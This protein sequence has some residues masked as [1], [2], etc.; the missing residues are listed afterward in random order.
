MSQIVTTPTPE[1]VLQD[2]FGLQAFRQGQAEIIGSVLAGQDTLAV[3][4]TG[5]GKSICYQIPGLIL[6][7]LTLVVSPLIALMEDQAQA[8]DALG[9]AAGCIH[10][11]MDR[12]RKAEVFAAMRESDDFVLYISPERACTEGFRRWFAARRVGLLAVDE[13]HCVSQWGHDFRPDYARIGELRALQPEV[14]MLALTATATPEVLEDI[15]TQLG[16]RD[17][18]R[19]VFGFYRPNLYYQVEPCDDEAV[20]DAWLR[21]AIEQVPE[22]RVLVYCGTR[23]QTERLGAELSRLFPQVGYYHAGLDAETRESIQRAYGAGEIRVLCATNAFGMGIDHPDVRL[24]VH[25][26]L[27]GNLESLYQ[28]MGRAGRDRNESTCLLLWSRRDIVLQRW[29]IDQSDGVAPPIRRRRKRALDLLVQYAEGGECRHGGILTYF[30]DSRRIE[31][32]GHCDACDPDSPRRIAVVP[33]VTSAM[34]GARN[35]RSRR[36]APA[37]AAPAGRA[38]DGVDLARFEALRAWRRETAMARGLPAFMVL[39]DKVL[40]ALA[41][42]DPS[43]FDELGSIHGMGPKRVDEFGADILRVLGGIEPPGEA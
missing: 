24:V 16:L 34:T 14:P 43:T 1:Q 9:I 27:P 7:G 42:H 22:G 25:A 41:V 31:S 15:S 21:A 4:P 20:R 19:H 30:R 29:F 18:D 38:L 39:S 3:M 17:P 12:R 40:R 13:A 5:G 8:L 28:E 32:C 11:G 6:G 37:L 36:R 26:H 35:K 10:S 2:R 33:G 23:S